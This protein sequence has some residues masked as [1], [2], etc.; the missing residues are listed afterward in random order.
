MKKG[1]ATAKFNVIIIDYNAPENTPIAYEILEGLKKGTNYTWGVSLQRNLSNS[2]QLNLNYEGR[3]PQ[4]TNI[5][6]TGGVQA[7]AFF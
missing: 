6:H 3:K 7:R 5:I 4:G 2:I 1:V